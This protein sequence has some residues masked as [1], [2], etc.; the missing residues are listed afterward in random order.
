M[1]T[2]TRRAAA[3]KRRSAERPTSKAPSKPA[4]RPAR[5]T[6]RA[7]TRPTVRV[8]AKTTAKAVPARKPERAPVAKAP[9]S[10]PD[11]AQK[12]I[13]A[14]EDRERRKDL[15]LVHQKKSE[16]N[17]DLK[18][19]NGQATKDRIVLLVR[20]AFW[21]QA[22]WDVSR[23]SVERAK[24]AMGA[25]WHSTVPVL[26]LLEVDYGTTTSAVE[27][28]RRDI[29]IH[30][31]VQNWYIDVSDPPRSFRVEIG[32]K[33]GDGKFFSIARSNIVS[34]P[35]PGSCDEIDENWKDIAENYDR[36][37]AM[38]G[39]YNEEGD[40]SELHDLFEERLRRPMGAPIVSRFG[41]GAARMLG[42]ESDFVFDVDAEM[43]V[44]GQTK[45]DARVTLS[46][47]PVKVRADGTFTVRLAMPDK[48]QV[49]PVVAAS[50]DGF[51]QRTV[52]LA[53]ERNTKVMEPVTHENNDV[54]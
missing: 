12:L 11:V 34:V 29:E 17:G 54:G 2:L 1:R 22:Y 23:L 6:E 18:H 7:A 24:A 47:D 4:A 13:A 30:G 40:T 5:P 10:R 14:K 36:I 44:Y 49:I 31:G 35:S 9:K 19:S 41:L 33:S 16:A 53:I 42:R 21:L 46:G 39:G 3:A 26:R 28:V 48:R 43:I 51:E 20:D 27:K 15:S 52:V 32:Y 38:S 37:F 25:R 8:P 50:A 45:P